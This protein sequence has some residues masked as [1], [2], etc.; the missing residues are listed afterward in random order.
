MAVMDYLQEEN[1]VLKQQLGG[2]RWR[3]TDP[4]R[5]RL[6]AKGKA[7]GRRLLAR[8]AT[9]VSP[10][11]ILAWHRRLIAAKWTFAHKRSATSS[12]LPRLLAF[13]LP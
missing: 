8:I 6:A 10:D 4:Q 9:I 11:T 7:L 12:P 1:R 3:L 13:D 2:R 5:R